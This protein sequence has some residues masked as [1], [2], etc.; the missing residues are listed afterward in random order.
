MPDDNDDHVE[1]PNLIVY[2]INDDERQW[3][4]RNFVPR[5]QD[6]TDDEGNERQRYWVF[7]PEDMSTDSQLTFDERIR[8]EEDEARIITRRD[9]HL[10]ESIHMNIPFVINEVDRDDDNYEVEVGSGTLWDLNQNLYRDGAD[11]QYK[12]S[13]TAPAAPIVRSR[14]WRTNF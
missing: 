2:R 9:S 6:S 12:Y 1:A 4:Y 13:S 5:E 7:E 10:T 3:N 8:K 11:R 14:T